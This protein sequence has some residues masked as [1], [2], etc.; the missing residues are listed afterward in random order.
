MLQCAH[1]NFHMEIVLA[2]RSVPSQLVASHVWCQ[3]QVCT[4]LLQMTESLPAA[5]GY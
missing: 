4:H 2:D 1:E 3:D 5:A